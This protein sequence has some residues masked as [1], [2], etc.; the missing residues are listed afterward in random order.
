MLVRSGG[1]AGTST[2]AVVTSGQA[3]VDTLETGRRRARWTTST[4][5]R[6]GG[7][8]WRGACMGG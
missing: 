6:T 2:H 8:E 7:R 1:A 5:R 4:A 3:V